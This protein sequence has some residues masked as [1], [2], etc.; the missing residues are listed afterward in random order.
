[1]EHADRIEKVLNL[2]ERILSKN[3]MLEDRVS[4]Q[5]TYI[6]AVDSR[7]TVIEKKM[8][9]IEAFFKEQGTPTKINPL[10][11]DPNGD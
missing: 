4:N 3:H 7:L 5:D 6:E 9:V 1:M 11:E 10:L 2:C 8:E